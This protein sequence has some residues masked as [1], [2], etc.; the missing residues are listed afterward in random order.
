[1]T[2]NRNTVEYV[3]SP[4]DL[5]RVLLKSFIGDML[6]KS[7]EHFK[8][9]SIQNVAFNAV[10]PMHNMSFTVQGG[11]R[12]SKKIFVTIS[13]EERESVSF[14][15]DIKEEKDVDRLASILAPYIDIVSNPIL[16]KKVKHHAQANNK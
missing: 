1:M 14:L 8:D 12:K 4:K 11:F 3:V 7:K 6:E 13:R 16:P 5:L 15:I 10:L 9:K 2:T